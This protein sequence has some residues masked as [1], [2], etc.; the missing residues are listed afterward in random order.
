MARP[1][2]RVNG[3]VN[4]WVNGWT[5]GQVDG[6][7]NETADDRIEG[8]GPD[9][10]GIGPRGVRDDTGVWADATGVSGVHGIDGTLGG[11]GGVTSREA[12]ARGI[13]PRGVAPWAG[14]VD[15]GGRE[16]ACCVG[17]RGISPGTRARDV[18]ITVATLGGIDGI[19]AGS[20]EVMCMGI[21]R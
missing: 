21:A 7:G 20:G 8:D 12:A 3:R 11:A 15:P 14:G 18:A 4:G 19:T 5:A 16:D 13:P 10:G 17:P 1:R 2:P 9:P 6:E